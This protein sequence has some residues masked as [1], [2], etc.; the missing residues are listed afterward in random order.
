MAPTATHGTTPFGAVQALVEATLTP[1]FT[2]TYTD[3][4][5]DPASGSV[6]ITITATEDTHGRA[7]S[8]T[9]PKTAAPTQ[10]V[11]TPCSGS[12]LGDGAASGAPTPW[13]DHRT[14][15]LAPF[16]RFSPHGTSTLR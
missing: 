15:R 7:S 11:A 12:T 2:Y 3:K 8:T 14:G 9:S 4:D 1:T 5:G 13:T 6:T 10:W 16:L